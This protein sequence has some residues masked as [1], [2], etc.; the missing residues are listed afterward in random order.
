MQVSGDKK[1]AQI[2]SDISPLFFHTVSKLVRAPVITYSEILQALAV[3]EDVL[4]PKPFQNPAQ[5]QLL[6]LG[7]DGVA[8]RKS[9]A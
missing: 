7:F 1:S 5:K 4:L 2:S 3:E 9:P 6:N 8:R